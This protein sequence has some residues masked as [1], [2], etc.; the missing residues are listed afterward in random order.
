MFLWKMYKNVKWLLVVLPVASQNSLGIDSR[1]SGILVC[2]INRTNHTF[3]IV[4][5]LICESCELENA[6]IYMILFS[7]AFQPSP[8]SP[9]DSIYFW[10]SLYVTS[11]PCLNQQQKQYRLVHRTHMLC[12]A[13]I[14]L[15]N[16]L[17]EWMQKKILI[18]LVSR[19][20]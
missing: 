9:L 11:A 8:F 15:K 10:G 13:D 16:K 12:Y 5:K 4:R 7:S 18:D 2:F 14:L 17:I 3:S 19:A 1:L 6:T 20:R